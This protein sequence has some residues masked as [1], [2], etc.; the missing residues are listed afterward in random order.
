MLG[1]SFYQPKNPK[2]KGKGREEKQ[3]ERRG[4]LQ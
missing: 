2:M 3:M 1:G 4:G